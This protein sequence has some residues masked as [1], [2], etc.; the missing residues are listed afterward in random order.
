MRKKN[1]G[2]SVLLSVMLVSCWQQSRVP[3]PPIEPAKKTNVYEIHFQEVSDKTLKSS[4]TGFKKTSKGIQPTSIGE[5]SDNL[6]FQHLSSE[7]FT[8]ETAGERYLKV[9]Y[10]ITNNTGQAIENLTFLP[11][12]TDDADSDPGNNPTPPTIGDTVFDRIYLFDGTQAPSMAPLMQTIRGRVFDVTTES[13]IVDASSTPYLTGLDVSGVTPAVPSGLVNGGV[14][15]EGWQ[16]SGIIPI[17]GTAVFT[18]AVK[19]PIQTPR[20]NN[21]YSFSL[22]VV[23][24]ED[25]STVGLT[26]IHDIQGATPAGDAVSP[27]LGNTVTID[28]IVTADLQQTEELGGF[29]VQEQTADQDSDPTTSEGVFVACSTSCAT[30]SAGDRVRLTA[31]VSEVGN[32]TRLIN[33]TDL[34]VM[35]TSQ[36]L[37]AA[38]AV[39][40]SATPTNWEQYEGMRV[41]TVGTVSDNSLLGRGGLVTVTD[42]NTLPAFTQENTPNAASF[43]TYETEAAARTITVDD[44]SLTEYPSSII[45]GRGNNPLS[46]G[47]TLRNGDG[48]TI[49]GVVGYSTSG[50]TG[51]DAYRIHA[52]AATATF[53]GGGRG[54]APTDSD[55]GNPQLK[56]ATFDVHDFFNGDGAGNSFTTEGASNAAELTRQQDKLVEAL[57][58]LDA[59][60]IAL[61]GVE[62]DYADTTPAIKTLTNALNTALGSTAYA[63]INPGSNLGSQTSAVGMLYRP[64]VLTPY[65]SFSV[66]DNTDNAAYNDVRNHPA[67]AQTFRTSGLGTFTAVAVDLEDRLTTCGGGDDDTTTG[68]GNCNGTRNTAAGILMDWVAADPTASGD[69]D[70]VLLGDFN[71]FMQ[72]DPVNA[73]LNGADGTNG[74]GDDYMQLFDSSD[75]TAVLNGRRGTLDYAFVSA[76]LQAQVQGSR[77]W[78]INAAEPSVLDYNTENKTVAQQ[79]ALYDIDVYRSS[80]HDPVVLGLTLDATN[81]APTDLDLSGSSIAENSTAGSTV[82]SFTTT[83]PNAGDTHTYSLVSGAGSTDNAAFTLSAAGVLTINAVPDFET[84]SS[85]S[86][87]VRTTDNGTPGLTYEEVFTLTVTDV[88]EAP[89]NIALSSSTI[90]ENLAAGS[91][92]GTFSTTDVDAGDTFIYTL[93]SGTGSTDNS[94]FTIVGNELRNA[95]AFDFETKSSYGIRVRATDA[96]GLF[97][98]KQF[99][100]TVND[101]VENG[102]PTDIG[103]SATSINENVSAGSTVGTLSTTDPNAGDTFTYTLVGGAGST[104]NASFTITGN[105]LTINASPDFETKSS[106]SVRIRSEDQGGLGFEKVFTISINNV[107]ET[108]TDIGLSATSINENVSAGST[109]GTFSS[110]DVDAGDSFTYTLVSGT[111][112]TDNTSFTITGNALTINASPDFEAKSSYSIRVRSTDAGGLFFEKQFTIS[113]NNV[114]ETP[115]DIGLSASSINENVSAGSTVGTLSSTDVDAGDSFTY[116]LVSGTGSTD[117]TSFT[118]T[119]NALTIN[120]SPDFE[121]K[122]SYSIR[123]RSTDAGGLFFEKQFTISINNVNETPTDIG[124]SASSI[125]ENV[126]AGSTVGTLSSTDVDAGDSFTYTLV[127]G[128][129]STDNTSFNILGNALRISNSPNFEAKSS[130]SIRVRSTDAGGLFFEKQFTITIVDVNEGPTAI[131]DSG[132]K[133]V[134]NTVLD[135][136]GTFSG[137]AEVQMTGNIDANDTDPDTNPAF[138]TLSVVAGTSLTTNNG[139]VT[140]NSDGSFV[141]TPPAGFN[142]TD[143]FNYTITDGSL[144]DVGQVSVAISGKVWYVQN[145]HPGA[146]KGLSSAP[147]TTLV[148]AQTA[149]GTGDTIY[150]LNGDGGTTGQNAGITLKS[151]QRLI[152]EGSGL[153]IGDIASVSGITSEFVGHS[154]GTKPSI[155]NTSGDGVYGLNVGTATIKGLNVT[156]GGA[157]DAINIDN[158]SGTNNVSLNNLTLTGG[159]GHGLFLNRTAG[160]LNVTAFDDITVSGNTGGSGINANTVNFSSITGATVAVGASGNGTGAS[161]VLLD[162]STGSLSFDSLNVYNDA[163]TGLKANNSGLTLVAS[164]GNIES[165]GGP[166][167]D[168]SNAPSSLAFTTVK[169]TNSSTTGVSLSGASTSTSMTFTAGSGSAITGADGHAFYVNS[170]TGNITY[171]GTIS[172]NDGNSGTNAVRVT[173]RNSGS[174]STISFTNAITDSTTD[175]AGG[176]YLD[177]N[178]VATINFSG[179]ITANT[180]SQPAFTAINGGTVSATDTSSTLTTSSGIAVNVQ[181]TSIGSSNLKFRSVSSNGASNGIVLNTTGSSGGLQV[182]GNGS[183]GTGGTIQNSTAAGISLTSTSKTSLSYLNVQS[184]A[185]HGILGSSV[186]DLTLAS[187]SITSNGNASGEHGVYITNLFGSNSITSTSVTNSAASNVYIQNNSG[188]LSALNVTGSTFSNTSSNTNSDNNFLLDAYNA[189]VINANITGNT[190]SST[191]NSH[192]NLTINNTVSGTVYFK[193]N[194]LTGGYTGSVGQNINVGA[195]STYTGSFNYEISGNNQTNAAAVALAVDVAG[196]TVQGKIT[197]NT[198]GTGDANPCVNITNRDG[199]NV[200]IQENAVHTINISNNI[201]NKC[202]NRGLYVSARASAAGLNPVANVTIQ[203]NQF[204]N[205][206]DANS[207]DSI[208]IESGTSSGTTPTICLNLGDASNAS[209]KNTV[210]SGTFNVTNRASRAVRLA[211]VTTSTFNLA[212]LS[213]GTDA[214]AATSYVN[215][216]T[217]FSS[218]NATAASGTYG[219]VGSCSTPSF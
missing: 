21:P 80:A 31:E 30:V 147:Y 183:S 55:L 24:A 90:D 136:A 28:G 121:A 93:V 128:T 142:G 122:S 99:T 41:S 35:A 95:A 193:N 155:S 171:N 1:L 143:T 8:V 11:F 212:G 216:R 185:D 144:T 170:G 139:S 81:L 23:Y 198:L 113:I 201:L 172:K 4:V 18:F 165:T 85:Y 36:T 49:T 158:T 15:S 87:R 51:T 219:S 65:G 120:A 12:D 101:L 179:Q 153:V 86:I 184:S 3:Q 141:Y 52:S 57:K 177:D 75:Y 157:G 9:R 207:S 78:H 14:M 71:A 53:T 154:A 70:V 88:N 189:A 82:G 118:I 108:P 7:V 152:G 124:L 200:R 174:A 33:A 167:V 208:F 109:V 115:T 180:A 169:S 145:N 140:L 27:E 22:M 97:F 119:G 187:D 173:S 203:G 2:L 132:F 48:A 19:H 126:S 210:V 66:L 194:T 72:E 91:A 25:P 68:Q 50:W 214:T 32:E 76:S 161:G 135:A 56:V 96:G 117:N 182:V 175:T 130:Y 89:S 64:S 215:A 73:V 123:V 164:T 43:A 10:K 34:I 131:D 37:P 61:Q 69:T 156:G 217:I 26:K 79:S 159:T 84:K 60:V 98:E 111:G 39:T 46:A 5:I 40:L 13:A 150:V 38:T 199:I 196:G 149:S 94:S 74:T 47:N 211:K 137:I 44:G 195:A 218:G 63:Y 16:K 100:I 176:I 112:S 162:G 107:N 102:A 181:N 192:F 202:T 125:N 20:K 197:G 209:L 67:L 58:D 204:S 190:F 6:S 138:N 166:A 104:D 114:N 59:D 205:F 45:F 168:I 62:N 17:G 213:G 129:G 110:T 163:G 127:S 92:V 134:G 160:T 191:K 178:D 105:T 106:Y 148:Q 54:P 151:N 42:L 77:I 188:T 206:T 186:T 133:T 83:D 103:L 116:T 146:N 29:Y